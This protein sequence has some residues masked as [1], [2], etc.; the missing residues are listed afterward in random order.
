M[1]QA[2]LTAMIPI[3]EL[4]LSIPVAIVSAGVPWYQALAV[5]IL[6]NMVPVL[7][8]VPGLERISKV[9][10][11]VS[12]PAGRL[13]EWRAK[14]LRVT[15]HARFQR[16]GALALLLFVA[17]P[18]PFTGAW[19]GSL[20]AWAFHVPNRAAILLIGAGVCIAGSV[21]TALTVAGIKI[22]ILLAGP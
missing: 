10:A 1:L 5:S 11:S 9:A 22:S 3:G 12:K 20:L 14:R 21:V 15:H 2:F 7:I 17:V 16:Y 8:L 18:L 19:T 6:G 13:L 4:R